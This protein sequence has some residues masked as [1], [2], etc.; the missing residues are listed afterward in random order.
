MTGTSFSFRGRAEQRKSRGIHLWSSSSFSLRWTIAAYLFLGPA[1]LSSLFSFSAP[2]LSAQSISKTSPVPRPVPRIDLSVVGYRG[3][4][5]MERLTDEVS[6]SLDFVDANHVLITFNPRKL[7]S[8][9]PDCPPGHDDR[10]IHAAVLEVPT[11]KIVNEADWYLHDHRHYLF[12]LGSGQFLLRRLNSL[13]LVDSAL[14]EKLLMRSPTNLSWVTVT[15]DRKQIIVGT[16]GKENAGKETQSGPAPAEGKKGREFQFEFLDADSL[17]ARRTVKLGGIEKLEGTSSGYADSIHKGGVYLVRFGPG[18]EQRQNVVRVRSRCVPEVFYP[19]S[20]SLLVGRCPL[21]GND[22]DYVVSA[23]TV[24]GRRLWRQHWSQH[25]YFPAIARNQDGSRF[26]ISTVVRSAPPPSPANSDDENGDN[27]TDTNHGLEQNIQVFETASGTAIQTVSVS[28]V[29]MSGQNFS[30]SPDGRRLAVLHDS[31]LE[32]YDLPAM[33][34]EEQAKFTALK[35]DVPGLYIVSSKSGEDSQLEPEA[36]EENAEETTEEAGMAPQHASADKPSAEQTRENQDASDIDNN[37][38]GDAALPVPTTAAAS[39]TED[40][41]GPVTTFKTSTQAVVVDVVVTDSKG[42]PVSGLH[43]QDFQLTEDGKPQNLR[44][45]KEVNGGQ[46]APDAAPAPAKPSPP[47]ANV[48]SNNTHAPDPGSVTLVL[49]DLL[50]T[51]SADQEHAREQLINFLKTKNNNSQFALCTLS[52]GRALHLRLIQGFTPDENLILAAVSGKSSAPEAARWQ[53]AA[54]GTAN[55]VSAV[56]ELAQ[57]GPTGGWA[58]LLHGLQA[59]QSEQQVT[60]TDARVGIT[61]DALTQLARY[62]SGIPG[63]KNLVWLSGSFPILIS[64]GA[65]FD[66]PNSDNRNYTTR[67]KQATNLLAEA[68]VA[69]YPV[70]VRVHGED[71]VVSASSK[72]VGSRGAATAPAPGQPASDE[73]VL[74]PNQALQP[75]MMQSLALRSAERDTLNQVASDTGG[76]AFFNSNAIEE[77]IATATEQGSHYYTLSY[78]PANRNYNGK[79]RKIKVAVADRGDRLH[80]RP[81]Y[82][83]D[84]PDAPVKHPDLYRNIGVAAMQHG[85]PQSRQVLFAVRVVPIGA[86]VKGDRAKAGILL[87][88]NASPGLPATVLPAAVEMQHYSI[89]YAI[90][91]ADLRFIPLE[92]EIHHCALSFMI[93]TFDEDGRQ[94]SGVSTLWSSDLN[95]A[96]YKDVISGGVRIHQEVDVPVKAVSLL[97]GIDDTISSHLGTLELPLPV[98]A[99]PD[100]PR[101]VKHSLPEIEPD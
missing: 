20:N 30:L 32:F 25:R 37:S 41:G 57:E 19:S 42:H 45:F 29:V 53:E 74:S 4:S 62:L 27:V 87:A 47:P 35:A 12:S 44:Y 31:E 83:A 72:G 51:P 89:D 34:E 97:L 50:N 81:G 48:F 63:R 14:Q 39:A 36:G 79:F 58:G 100:V 24:T 90:D 7:L 88:P 33:S 78:S 70:D 59:M 23:F 1:F 68:Q 80:Y 18:P 93:A 21:T 76:K 101:A 16:A 95:P 28:P 65:D 11:G 22:S 40:A 86:K 13:Y 75:G 84:D 66:N 26:A 99:P 73:T 52:S 2:T 10:L 61:I 3:L 43:Q 54:T 69:V 77:A 5:Q 98:P 94:L 67:I 92:N 85:S 55:S 15:P 46:T 71:D 82:F 56:N 91:S 9:H 49:L 38:T 96:A 64:S 6:M 8:R 60:D 17:A